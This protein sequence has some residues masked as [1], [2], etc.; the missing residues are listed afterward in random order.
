MNVLTSLCRWRYLSIGVKTC[1][2]AR[3]IW[4]R[5]HHFV[6]VIV[7]CVVGRKR[8][9]NASVNAALVLR[10]RHS[11]QRVFLYRDLI[12]FFI[13]AWHIVVFF[14]FLIVVTSYEFDFMTR[15][16]LLMF[17]DLLLP[18]AAR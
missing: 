2:G 9:K 15:C 3:I 18:Q 12:L 1:D 10:R 4:E 8:S 16:E 13:F 6:M 14:V 7:A 17:K 11:A 5:K